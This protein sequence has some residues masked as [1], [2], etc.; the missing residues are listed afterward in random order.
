ME[1]NKFAESFLDFS[2]MPESMEELLKGKEGADTITKGKIVEGTIVAK[3]P[4][5]AL[6]QIRRAE[7]LDD[8][9]ATLDFRALESFS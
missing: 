5:G 1:E 7:T 9:F 2:G 4:D 8:L 6:V 3:R